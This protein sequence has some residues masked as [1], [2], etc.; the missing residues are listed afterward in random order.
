[1]TE[2]FFRAV[3]DRLANSSLPVMIILGI[4][5]EGLFVWY[6]E[7]GH[8]DLF[9]IWILVLGIL[10]ILVF[11]DFDIRVSD[12]RFVRVRSSR[13]HRFNGVR[14]DGGHAVA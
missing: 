12:W 3:P 10:V 6:F 11:S 9:E 8:W 5:V 1:M 14:A 7:F 13:H 2:T 4:F